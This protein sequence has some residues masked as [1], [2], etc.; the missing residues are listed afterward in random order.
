VLDHFERELLEAATAEGANPSEANLPP[1]GTMISRVR[2]DADTG[3]Q[4]IEWF[5]TE[6]IKG[7]TRPGHAAGRRVFCFCKPT[8]T[9]P[10]FAGRVGS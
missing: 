1:D 2:S 9:P 4:S 8:R 6:F 3:A 7:M 10:G 5:G